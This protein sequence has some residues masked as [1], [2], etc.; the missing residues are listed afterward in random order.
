VSLC[1]IRHIRQYFQFG[2]LPNA[3]TVCDVDEKLFPKAGPQAKPLVLDDY[4][5]LDA[6]R[7]ISQAFAGS[8]HFPVM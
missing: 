7:T 8:I 1:T 4:Q 3:G 2:M 6:A 5:L